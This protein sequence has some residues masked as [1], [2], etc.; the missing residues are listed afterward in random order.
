VSAQTTKTIREQHGVYEHAHI[1]EVVYWRT[2]TLDSW[3]EKQPKLIPEWTN[4]DS[5]RPMT[6]WKECCGGETT[7]KS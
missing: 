5:M 4:R 7:R 2:S 1:V 6:M 3:Y